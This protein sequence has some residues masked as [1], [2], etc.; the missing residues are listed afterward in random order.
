[1][2]VTAAELLVKVGWDDSAVDKGAADSESKISK[3]GGVM[4]TAALGLSGAA[5]TG[6]GAV[7][8]STITM[9][10]AMTPIGTLL[11]TQSDQFKELSG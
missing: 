6:V 2:S 5:V 3:L 1:M 4:K 7:I 10:D 11:G 9:Q 8:A